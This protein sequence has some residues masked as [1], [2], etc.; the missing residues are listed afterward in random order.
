M[1]CGKMHAAVSEK[2]RQTMS[3][4][5]VLLRASFSTNLFRGLRGSSGC[6]KTQQ[7]YSRLSVLS[8]GKN[9]WWN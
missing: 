2:A 1:A 8:A 6:R 4:H 7:I 5:V 3:E 9:S